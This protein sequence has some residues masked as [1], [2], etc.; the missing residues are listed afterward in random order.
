M[1]R[2]KIEN[3]EEKIK[4]DIKEVKTKV[5]LQEFCVIISKRANARFMSTKLSRVTGKLK[6]GDKFRLYREVKGKA[7]LNS[8]VW[9]HTVKGYIHSSQSK[10][11]KEEV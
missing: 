8:N 2:K 3:K 7:L 10:V 6:Q 1:G 5:E 11:V 4:E 9:Y